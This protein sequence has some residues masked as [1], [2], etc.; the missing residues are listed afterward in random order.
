MYLVM[1]EMP[2]FKLSDLHS[3]KQHGYLLS[4]RLIVGAKLGIDGDVKHITVD[5]TS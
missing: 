2:T 1:Q 4:V 3:N 5:A